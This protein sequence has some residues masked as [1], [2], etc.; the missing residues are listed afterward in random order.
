MSTWWFRD[1]RV[2]NCRS[3][4][5]PSSEW[6]L[7]PNARPHEESIGVLPYNYYGTPML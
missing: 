3:F 1:G 4:A 6:P 2:D 5:A 7:P